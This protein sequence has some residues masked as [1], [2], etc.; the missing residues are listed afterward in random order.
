LRQTY[1]K[2]GYR[3]A[4]W[5]PY[6]RA[7][8]GPIESRLAETDELRLGAPQRNKLTCG[9]GGTPW[10]G[11]ARHFTTPFQG[12]PPFRHDAPNREEALYSLGTS[13]GAPLH[14][15]IVNHGARNT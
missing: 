10:K 6:Y 4:E 1:D 7:E 3:Q 15:L 14:R 12:V 2:F 8:A 9:Q 11:V 13:S 5:I